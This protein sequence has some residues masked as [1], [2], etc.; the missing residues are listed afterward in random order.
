MITDLAQ[1]SVRPAAT[2]RSAMEHVNLCGLGIVLLLDDDDRFIATVTDG[3]IR[4]AILRGS[5]LDSS[6]T[7]A[8][9]NSDGKMRSSISADA[10]VTRSEQLA[11]MRKAEIRHLPLLDKEGRLA[12]L[13][14]SD[15]SENTAEL[16][17][18][19]VI[20]AGGFGTRLRPLTDSTP[21]PMLPIA[22]RPLMERTIE[23]LQQAGVHRINVT[24]HYMP[25]KITDHFGSGSEFGVELNYV[26]EDEPLGTAGAIGLLGEIND[27]LLVINGDI[28]TTADYRS[29]IRFHQDRSAMMTVGVRH[30]DLQVPYGVVESENGRVYGLREKPTYDFF[31]NA[32]VYLLDPSV[33]QYIPGSGRYDMTDLI[34]LLLKKGETV[35]SFP[36]IEYWIDIGQ[37][38]DFDRAQ[39]EVSQLRNAA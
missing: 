26:S 36:I 7:H 8:L 32:G 3:D 25:E 35:A 22:G 11:I 39:R 12:G 37:H 9:Q 29:L 17:V 23:G 33:Q 14:L 34:E 19:A 28:L 1:L 31:V 15:E 30:Y 21:K 16:P 10:T 5:G 27:P 20:M 13:A 24:T 38:D 4:R 6:V 2:L 18:Q